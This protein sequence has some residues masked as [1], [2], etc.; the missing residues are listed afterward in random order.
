MAALAS[1]DGGRILGADTWARVTS[2]SALAVVTVGGTELADYARGGAA[3]EAVWITAQARGLSVQ[4]VSPAFL[5]A[6]TQAEFLG[7]S[8]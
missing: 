8:A 5:Y 6:R 7:V 1:W 3:T 4:P 2:S